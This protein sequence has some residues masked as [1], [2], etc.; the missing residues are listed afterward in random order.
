MISIP[1]PHVPTGPAGVSAEVADVNYL[2]SAAENIEYNGKGARLWGETVKS[3]VVD[4]LL[5]VAAELE[6]AGATF[7]PVAVT[8]SMPSVSGED[9]ARAADRLENLPSRERPS[10][11]GVTAMVVQ[12]L[13]DAS[14]QVSSL[15]Q[16]PARTLQT[17]REVAEGIIAVANPSNPVDR[18]KVLAA[19][20][21][22]SA[23]SAR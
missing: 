23:M 2:R 20:A 14:A 15:P 4:L 16:K 3:A 7:S 22:L 13:R 18:G 12:L 6:R 8:I 9:L 5:N 11:S 10:G 1:R 19:R 17:A 21:I